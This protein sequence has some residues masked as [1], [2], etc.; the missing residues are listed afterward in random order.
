ML[1]LFF[2]SASTCPLAKKRKLEENTTEQSVPKISKIE[3]QSDV[4]TKKPK[5]KENKVV[6]SEKPFP[7]GESVLRDNKDKENVC[8]EEKSDSIDIKEEA[9]EI[10]PVEVKTEPE[11]L[12]CFREA[13][14]ALRRLSDVGNENVTYTVELV[15]AGNETVF[16]KHEV[17]DVEMTSTDGSFVIQADDKTEK[18][19]RTVEDAGD[20]LSSIE[21]KCAQIQ[22]SESQRKRSGSVLEQSVGSTDSVSGASQNILGVLDKVGVSSVENVQNIEDALEMNQDDKIGESQYADSVSTM[23]GNLQVTEAKE[24]KSDSDVKVSDLIKVVPNPDADDEDDGEDADDSE[25]MVLAEW[26]EGK[27]ETLPPG[28]KENMKSF[29]S[30]FVAKGKLLYSYR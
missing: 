4:K 23:N 7:D 14:Q 3:N 9:T 26:T 6:E 16:V 28:E 11:E 25:Y 29:V 15:N 5:N 13:E 20:I 12:D 22:S 27:E 21:E 1:N 8:T 19:K 24:E 30:E 18:E 17:E 2:Y 10:V